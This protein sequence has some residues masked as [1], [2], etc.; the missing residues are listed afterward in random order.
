ME[1]SKKGQYTI[2]ALGGLAIA[3]VVAAII[4][5]MGGEIL[6]EI[7]DSMDTITINVSHT[8]S[9]PVQLNQTSV[10]INLASPT[11]LINATYN[12]SNVCYNTSG[13]NSN[14]YRIPATD[15]NV[16]VSNSSIQ[17]NIENGAHNGSAWYCDFAA[18]YY[19][20]TSYNATQGGLSATETFGS[21]LDT[22]A[23]IVVA[24]VVIGIIVVCFGQGR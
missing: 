15:Y 16:V 1:M 20:T 2:G 17:F 14:Q 5:A 6:E 11:T 13:N 21:W 22:I 3:M 10:S 19:G 18:T 24:A 23:L 8:F 12:V 7:Q 4:I 9:D